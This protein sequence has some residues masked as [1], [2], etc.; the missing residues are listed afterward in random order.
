MYIE[1][2]NGPLDVKKLTIDE[3]IVLADEMRHALLIRASMA[4]I[5]D[6]ILVW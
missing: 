5:L 6:L 1:K 2:I 4:D 3:L